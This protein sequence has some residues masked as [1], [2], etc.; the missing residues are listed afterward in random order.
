MF[1]YLKMSFFIF[2]LCIANTK[3][4]A[5]TTYEK[6]YEELR[7]EYLQQLNKIDDR[8]SELKKKIDKEH[9]IKETFRIGRPYFWVP[10]SMGF[11]AFFYAAIKKIN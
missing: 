3:N 11:L 6:M 8:I 2:F 4:F 5:I 9:S 10:L 1:K 7:K